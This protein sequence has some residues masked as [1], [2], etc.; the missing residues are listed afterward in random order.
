MLPQGIA[1]LSYINLKLSSVTYVTPLQ[2]I[3]GVKGMDFEALTRNKLFKNM[4]QEEIKSLLSPSALVQRRTFKKGQIVAIEDEVCNSIGI[5]LRGTVE[6]KKASTSGKEYTIAML[7]E[8]ETIG[9][10]IIFSSKTIFPATIY[11]KSETEIM[12]ISKDAIMEMCK[13]SEKFLYNFLNILS[14]R[15]LLLNAKLKEST[16][17]TLRQRLCKFLIEEYKKQQ[18]LRIKLSLTREELAEAFNVQRPSLSRELARMKKEELIDFKGREIWIK[19][20]DG[21]E[22]GLLNPKAE[23]P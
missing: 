18:S 20:L 4:S 5:I 3:R 10:A 21:I 16:L 19:S 14:D 9:E 23:E 2:A 6:V 1:N 22:K 8:G 11:S 7:S 15:I 12:F 17:L 13:I